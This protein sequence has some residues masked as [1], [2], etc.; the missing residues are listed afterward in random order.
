MDIPI[1]KVTHY[2]DTIAVAVVEVMNQPLRVGDRIKFSGEKD[3][4][5][6][7]I[8]SLQV[9]HMQVSEVLPGESGGITVEHPVHVGDMV[10][11]LSHT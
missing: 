10:Y 11:L 8:Q 9:E 4:V 7:T 1:A 2:Y 6:Q 5:V 3:D